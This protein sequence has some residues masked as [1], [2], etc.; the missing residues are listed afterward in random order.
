MFPDINV[1]QEAATGPRTKLFPSSSLCHRSIIVFLEHC[2][3]PIAPSPNTTPLPH[4][5]LL[6][7]SFQN[8]FHAL[9]TNPLIWPGSSSSSPKLVLYFATLCLLLAH[10]SCSSYL[11]SLHPKEP[12]FS[13]MLSIWLP[14]SFSTPIPDQECYLDGSLAGFSLSFPSA[15]ILIFQLH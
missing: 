14:Q 3:Q 4:K 15:C 5:A 7:R 6:I 2:Y 9:L 12:D 8:L 11:D 10:P 13:T 1:T